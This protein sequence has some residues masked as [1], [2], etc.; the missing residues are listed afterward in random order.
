MRNELD[1][2]KNEWRVLENR[3]RR[4][5]VADGKEARLVWKERDG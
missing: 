5:I 3:A 4:Y 1:L 2:G